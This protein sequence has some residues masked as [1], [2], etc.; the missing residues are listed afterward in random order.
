MSPLEEGQATFQQLG[1]WE[2]TGLPANLIHINYIEDKLIPSH[3]Q[4]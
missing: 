3:T 1:L 2:L 4:P